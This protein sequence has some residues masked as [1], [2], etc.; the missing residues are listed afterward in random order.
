MII[1]RRLR[2]VH[3]FL[4]KIRFYFILFF[5]LNSK[6]L[7]SYCLYSSHERKLKIAEANV[8]ERGQKKGED[9][10]GWSDGRPPLPEVTEFYRAIFQIDSSIILPNIN[11]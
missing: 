2:K 1:I 3:L 7:N 5:W 4:K 10:F 11:V 9:G 6:K 8:A